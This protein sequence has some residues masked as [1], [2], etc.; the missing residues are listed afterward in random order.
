[1]SLEVEEGSSF[2]RVSLALSKMG[3]KYS[4]DEKNL[5]GIFSVRTAILSFAILFLMMLWQQRVW[6]LVGRSVCE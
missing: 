1:M 2:D 6:S 3:A 5:T 4:V